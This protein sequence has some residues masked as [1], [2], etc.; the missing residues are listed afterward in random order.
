MTFLMQPQDS[1]Q[2]RLLEQDATFPG[3]ELMGGDKA[4]QE[5]SDA[6]YRILDST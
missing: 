3:F 1:P 2:P 5:V 4:P 6:R